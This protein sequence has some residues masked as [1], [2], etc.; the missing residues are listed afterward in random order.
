MHPSNKKNLR[1]SLVVGTIG[2]STELDRL[3]SSLKTQSQKNFEVIIVDQNLDQ[4]VNQVIVAYADTFPIKHVQSEIGL[5]HARNVGLGYA[6]GEL[7]AFPD[8]DCWYP[9]SA[10]EQVDHFFCEHP[11]IDVVNGMAID[12]DGVPCCG[13]WDTKP[14]YINRWNVWKRGISFTIFMR[15]KVIE[16]TG[17]FD[18]TLGVGT[19]SGFSAGEETSYLLRA[20]QSGVRIYYNPKI[21]IY[22]PTDQPAY[23][24]IRKK[25]AYNYG[26]GL[27]RVLRLH[28][29]PVWFS[30][31]HMLR[32]LGGSF[33]ALVTGKINKSEYHFQLF[34]GKIKGWLSKL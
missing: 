17:L 2:R 6:S 23:D 28:R 10:L 7:I 26:M 9:P 20:I 4:R 24:S 18:E 34:K 8:D 21:H 19:T 15:S 13:R 32:P 22:H 5:S 16:T 11:T 27:G 30:A 33:L 25:R 1:F 14:G 31:Y 12:T 29:Y 3:L